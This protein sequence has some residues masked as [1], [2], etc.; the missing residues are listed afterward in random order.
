MDTQGDKS[1]LDAWCHGTTS[2]PLLHPPLAASEPFCLCS[3]PSTST[4][5]QLVMTGSPVVQMG[6]RKS[7]RLN[8]SHQIISYAVFS[9]KKKKPTVS[10]SLAPRHLHTSYVPGCGVT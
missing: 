10:Q 7:T 2:L 6:D 8:S 1:L 3:A 9:L 4:P 5:L